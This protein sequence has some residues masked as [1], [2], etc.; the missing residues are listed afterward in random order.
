MSG[1][2]VSIPTADKQSFTGY[3]AIPE[4]GT[5]PGVVLLQ[6]VFGVNFHIRAVADLYAEEGYVVLAP[7]LFWRVEPRAE[8]EYTAAGRER[9]MAIA[10]RFD[11]DQSIRDVGDALVALR[12]MPSCKSGAG[13]IGFCMGG[14]LA[15]L[16]AARCAVDAAVGYYPSWIQNNL[17]EA[18]SIKCPIALHIGGKDRVTPPPVIAA[19]K[20][21]M[22]NRERAAV[23][24]YPEAE[25]AFNNWHRPES[26]HAPSALL[27]HSRSMAML[28]ATL[29][30]R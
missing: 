3:L 24:V 15:F 8:L 11:V 13:V 16:A 4:R 26:F 18:K 23:H 9:A 1:I 10:Q 29:G 30:A 2:T 7:D 6:E 5:G 27:A 25:H 12:A 22:A 17:A 14:R 20:Q 21:A 19:V 28:R